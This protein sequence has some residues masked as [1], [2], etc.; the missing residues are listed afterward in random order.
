M[1]TKKAE[2]KANGKAKAARVLKGDGREG[3]ISF[4]AR[5]L[6]KSGKTNEETFRALVKKF[7]AKRIPEEHKAYPQWYRRQLVAAGAIAKD[8]AE[9]HAHA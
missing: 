4:V 5:Q 7:G 9:K 3:S 6:I 1:T 8:W 2:K